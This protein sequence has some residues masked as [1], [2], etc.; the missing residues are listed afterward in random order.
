MYINTVSSCAL[1]CL[2]QLN[3]RGYSGSACSSSILIYPWYP[4]R[5]IWFRRYA[6]LCC[7]QLMI[8][9]SKMPPQPLSRSSGYGEGRLGTKW[10]EMNRLA[11][12]VSTLVTFLVR[13]RFC[14][15]YVSGPDTFLFWWR[16]W[17][18]YASSLVTFLIWVCFWSGYVSSPDTFMVWLGFWSGYVSSLVTFLALIRLWSGLVSG[19]DTFPIWIHF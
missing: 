11:G 14:S 18:G 5:V 9:H 12:Y 4:K 7:R 16:F 2:R 19:P 17:S 1:P 15:G 3:E 8:C 10:R 13:I 6:V